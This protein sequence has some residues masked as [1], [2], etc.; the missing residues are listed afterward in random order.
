MKYIKDQAHGMVAAASSSH[1]EQE[2]ICRRFWTALI[3]ADVLQE[4]EINELRCKYG[5]QR[6]TTENLQESISRYAG[7]LAAFCERLGWHD[8]EMLIAKFQ[9]RTMTG[10]RPEILPLVEIRYVQTYT[11]RLLYRAGIKTPEALAALGDVDRVAHILAAGRRG[12]GKTGAEQRI[13]QRQARNILNSARDLLAQKAKR[14]RAEASAA[15]LIVQQGFEGRVG[16]NE[17]IDTI[18]DEPQ[19]IHGSSKNDQ[20]AAIPHH[21]DNQPLPAPPSRS[22]TRCAP[23][24][25]NRTP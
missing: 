12:G 24:P 7:M 18:S 1:K 17:A 10:A 14:L 5:I 11:A 8:L 4:T 23:A 25:Q 22:Q 3:L 21:V 2:R 15:L 13:Y 19:R 16:N 9:A 6:A 20:V